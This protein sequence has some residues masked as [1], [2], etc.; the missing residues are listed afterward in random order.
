MHRIAGRSPAA[1]ASQA[2]RPRMEARYA[3]GRPDRMT[4]MDRT[5]ALEG[6]RPFH[7]GKRDAG[8]PVKPTF[9]RGPATS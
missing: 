3:G 4:Q 5:A 7:S 2:K 9:G 8:V 1:I 6:D